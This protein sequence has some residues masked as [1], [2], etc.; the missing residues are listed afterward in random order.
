MQYN[1]L[2][3]WHVHRYFLV[4]CCFP[5]H[6]AF[7]SLVINHTLIY[8]SAEIIHLFLRTKQKK[9]KRK[10]GIVLFRL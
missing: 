4:R 1:E 8:D 3:T 2:C 9:R 7:L 6:E 5:K 10:Q